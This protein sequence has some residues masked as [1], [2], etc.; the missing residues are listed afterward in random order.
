MATFIVSG[1]AHDAAT[2][3]VRSSSTFVVTPW[4]LLL[5][6]SVLVARATGMDLSRRPWWVRA[7][8]NTGYLAGSL[9]VTVYATALLGG[10]SQCPS[11]V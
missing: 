4:F 9:T 8:A 5:S 7:A 11:V 3:I 10:W 2:T 1:I 6:I